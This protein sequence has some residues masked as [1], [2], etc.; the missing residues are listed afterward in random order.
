MSR[1]FLIILL[2]TLGD[3]LF[4]G[5]KLRENKAL[6]MSS[7]GMHILIYISIL[8]LF[9]PFLLGIT[10][11]QAIL[12]SI[13]N[14]FL[15]LIV[16]FFFRKLKKGYK[17]FDLKKYRIVVVTDQFLHIFAL[18]YSYYLLIPNGFSAEYFN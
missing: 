16:D 18:L 1:I 7:L 13:I 14:G 3:F 6:K 9:S 10:L 2:H 11:K 4:Q 5:D 17:D 8:F 12:F 15:H